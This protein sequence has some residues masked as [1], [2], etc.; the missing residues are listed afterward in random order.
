MK[1]SSS[2]QDL[3]AGLQLDAAEGRALRLGLNAPDRL[4]IDKQEVVG[5]SGAERTLA[6][7]DPD[8]RA[9]VRP[10]PVLHFP[11]GGSQKSVDVNSGSF[12]GRVHEGGFASWELVLFLGT[13]VYHSPAI[14]EN[15]QAAG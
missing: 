14:I 11:T 4:A 10:T 12:F 5:F 3:L 7:G 9:Q 1:F 15:R 8:G 2:T 13:Q 6:H